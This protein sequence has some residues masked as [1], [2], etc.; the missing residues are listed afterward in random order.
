[1]NIVVRNTLTVRSQWSAIAMCALD[2]LFINRISRVSNWMEYRPVCIRRRYFSVYSFTL[3]DSFR[4]HSNDHL[5][6]TGSATPVTYGRRT[7]NGPWTT[8]GAPPMTQMGVAD[9]GEKDWGSLGTQGPRQICGVCHEERP[10]HRAL[11]LHVDA[12]FLLDFCPCGFHDVFPY[13]VL[14]HKMDCFAGEGHVVDKDCFL[15]YIDAIGPVIMKAITL[16][17]LDAGFQ[18]LLIAARQQSPMIRSL[19]AAPVTTNDETPPRPEKEKTPTP[20]GPSRLATVEEP[21]L[22]L[23]AEFTQ[24][25]PDLLSTTTGLYQLKDS[26][27]RLK[28]RLRAHQARHRSQ[29]LQQKGLVCRLMSSRVQRGTTLWSCEC[30]VLLALDPCDNP[31]PLHPP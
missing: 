25:T 1:M 16:A 21:L 4:S 6:V 24:L 5:Q 7:G 26:V 27:G 30:H 12:H 8:R 31:P 28:R 29:S 3:L 2:Q 15:Q 14:L 22:R 20:P 23:Q 10:S 9:N 18:R 13:P 17:V 19:P 11:R